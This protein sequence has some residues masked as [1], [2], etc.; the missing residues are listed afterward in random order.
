MN[1]I[2]ITEKIIADLKQTS[3][4]KQS[5]SKTNFIHGALM[6]LTRAE[7]YYDKP[8]K[9]KD[10]HANESLAAELERINNE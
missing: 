2:D 4:F 9:V 1:D 5:D 6:A 3:A 10:K 7:K 8:A